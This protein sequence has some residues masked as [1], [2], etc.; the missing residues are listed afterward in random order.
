[1]LCVRERLYYHVILG[2][3]IVSKTICLI[4][5][6]AWSRYQIYQIFLPFRLSRCKPHSP[7]FLSNWLGLGCHHYGDTHTNTYHTLPHIWVLCII[8]DRVDKNCL[9]ECVYRIYLNQMHGNV[10][11]VF[12]STHRMLNTTHSHSYKRHTLTD[13]SSSYIC[14]LFMA[15]SI[16][17]VCYFFLT[18][19]MLLLLYLPDL[20]FPFVHCVSFILI[21]SLSLTI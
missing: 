5:L 8:F 14:I 9:Y 4:W 12:P 3:Y 10:F 21:S 15:F 18:L 17:N 19:P 11:N 6:I 2:C 16:W 7:S 13:S 1:M 20:I